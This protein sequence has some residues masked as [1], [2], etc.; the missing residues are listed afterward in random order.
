M[1][2]NVFSVAIFFICFRESLE[3]SVIVSVLLSFLH[4]TLGNQEDHAT[5]KRLYKQ[6]CSLPF[7]SF[8]LPKKHTKFHRLMTDAAVIY[9]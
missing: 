3:T 6:V 2:V 5:R 8:C 4:Q 9:P 7:F 1:T